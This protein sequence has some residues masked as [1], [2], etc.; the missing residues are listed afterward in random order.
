[1]EGVP[2]PSWGRSN[3]HHGPINH[4]YSSPW[5]PILQVGETTQLILQGGPKCSYNPCKWPYRLGNWGDFTLLIGAPKK[6]H[7]IMVDINPKKP[8]TNPS[9]D[10]SKTPR[11]DT[12]RIIPFT[13]WFSSPWL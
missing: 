10:T 3:D 8:G 7:I 5:E 9:N 4:V 12:W 2:Q 6:M 11:G 1:M 13:T